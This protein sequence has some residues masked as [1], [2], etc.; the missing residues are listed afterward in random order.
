MIFCDLTTTTS[1][2]FSSMK[3]KSKIRDL[4]NDARAEITVT[5]LDWP[6]LFLAERLT[7]SGFFM[8]MPH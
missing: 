7:E 5:G 2:Q 8:W 1:I 6:K 4:K 3:V